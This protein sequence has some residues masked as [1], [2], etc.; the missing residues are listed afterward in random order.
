MTDRE[1]DAIEG[2]IQALSMVMTALIGAMDK[3]TLARTG[4]ALA[5][6]QQIQKKDTQTPPDQASMRDLLID[7]YL[8]LLLSGSKLD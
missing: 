4:C 6:E 3:M 1:I 5:V 7:A 8:S 2:Q